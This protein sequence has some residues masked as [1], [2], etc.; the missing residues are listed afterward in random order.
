MFFINIS[1]VREFFGAYKCELLTTSEVNKE[2]IKEFESIKPNDDLQKYIRSEKRAWTDDL[3]GETRVYLIKDE[4]GNIACYF[5]IKCGLLV[6]EDLNEKLAD[7]EKE[8]LDLY[9]NAKKDKDEEAEK[10]F[11]D[12]INSMFPEKADDIFKIALKRIE[13][14]TEALEINQSESTINVPLCY[15]AIEVKHLCRNARY[16]IPNEIKVPVGFGLFW[17]KIVPLIE[18]ISNKIGC[19]Y[20]YIFAADDVKKETD[21]DIQ[22]LVRHYK[23]DLKFSEC[24]EGLKLIKPD[25]DNYCYGLVQEISKLKNNRESVWEEF[26]DV[27]S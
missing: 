9:V 16:V 22:K 3:N 11:Y 6:G 25:Y 13:R 10:G 5:S 23:N 2:L 7:D 15:S 18:E 4:V 14:K 8:L 27:W 1:D 19:K 26:S 21:K 24:G 12:A 20:V 17:E